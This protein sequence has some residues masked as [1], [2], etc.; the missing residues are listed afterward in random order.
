MD[1]K[2]YKEGQSMQRPP[3][4]EENCFIY[5]KKR[6]ETYVKSK[7]IDLWYIIAHGNYKPTIKDK[8]GK[9]IAIPY[10]NFDENHKKMIF[11]NDEAKMV[12][13]NTLP[14]K[15]YERIF[16][17]DTAQNTWDSLITTHQALDESFS[18]RRKFLRALPPNGD[19]RTWRLQRTRKK[20]YKSL[21]LKARQVLSDEDAS[22]SD[23]N[24][25]EYAMAVRDFKKFFRRRGKF[26]RQPY[27]DKK[28]FRKIKEDKKED[29]RCLKC[30]DP[31]HFISDC[32]KNSLGDQK[33]FVVG[34]WSDSGD[35]SKKKEIC[36]MAHST[37]DEW[38]QDSGCSRH[39]TGNKDL[40]SSYK[41]FNGGN[42]LFA[43]N[44]KSKI[45]GKDHGREFDNEVQF[46]A[47]CDANGIT[48]NF[49]ALCTPQSN[50]VVERRKPNQEYFK[51]FGSKCFILNTKDY[52]TKSDPKATEGIFLGYSHNSKAY[53]VLNKETMKVKESL[54][55]KFD[56]SA[57]PK[58]PPL[59]DD[60]LLEIIIIENQDKDLEV[61]QNEPLNK[62][63]ANI[64]ESKDHTIEIVTGSLN[65][66]TLR[67]QMALNNAQTKIN[68]LAFRSMLEKH[69]LTGPNFNELFRALKLV[70]RTEKLQNVFETALSPAPAAGAD[71][72]ALADWAVLFYCHNEVTCFTDGTMP[73]KL[74][75]QFKHNS[76]LE[77]VTELQKMYGKPSGV[78][79]HELVN[80]FHSCK[81]AEGQFVSDHVLLMK[82]YLDQLATLNYD[83]PDKVSISFILN[84]L[85]SEF[86]A[87]CK[88]TICNQ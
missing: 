68:S 14:K 22:S 4:F 53:I 6:F 58:S 48:H 32:P 71:A 64:K 88:I 34:S 79:L 24:D 36:L 82:I 39:M 33:A 74:Y 51:V 86:Q 56:E 52:L 70:V 76:P 47:F 59:V 8:D 81:H 80:M 46:G 84:L 35:D 10:E 13:Y 12:L 78:E 18:S 41:T 28:N 57:P 75:Q 65:Q 38:I 23:S 62:D 29:R 87:L 83:F 61:K 21:A 3:L 77:M 27:D 20:K 30:G 63:I 40:F 54:N 85:L 7:D 25:E 37:E 73:L 72:Q 26:V 44:T 17:C 67:S 5:W 66:R 42:V 45:I 43:S 16:M 15:E 11:K 49:S 69:Q 31:N 9:D 50:G 55:I 1:S 60:D 19:H 2:N